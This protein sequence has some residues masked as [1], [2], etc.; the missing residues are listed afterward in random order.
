MERTQTKSDDKCDHIS[1]R[2]AVARR[3]RFICFF[4]ASVLGFQA[5]ALGEEAASRFDTQRGGRKRM[6][7]D[8]NRE[9]ANLA[10]FPVSISISG[11]SKVNTSKAGE[12]V[13]EGLELWLRADAISGVPE[14]VP[15]KVWPGS[16]PKKQTAQTVRGHTGPVFGKKM[17]NGKV[18]GLRFNGRNTLL[19]LPKLCIPHNTTAF[20]VCQDRKQANG[21][22]T[23]HGLLVASGK[24]DPY[25]QKTGSGY[26]ISYLQAGMDGF[27]VNLRNGLNNEY[28]QSNQP[29]GGGMEL[30]TFRKSGHHAELYRDGLAVTRANLQRDQQ[31]AYP[32]GYTLGG[33]K[34]K[35][36]YHGVIAEILVYD[37]ALTDAEQRKTEAYLS[38][39]Y[40]IP[41]LDPLAD[42]PRFID[43][44]TVIM[45][46]G[47]VDQPYL[48]TLKDGSWL[49][50]STTSLTSERGKD[51]T[52]VLSRSTDHGKT[53]T[54]PKSVI[55]ADEA[56]Q[57]S[58][59]TLCTTPFGRVYV[60]YNLSTT[61][62]SGAL[63]S[64]CY[65]FSDDNGKTWSRRFHLP[66]RKTGLDRSGEPF[67]SWSV[68][69]PFA[70]DGA[71]YVSFSKFL[72]SKK[73]TGEG[74]LIRSDNLMT[75]K[76][77]DQLRWEMLPGGE[78]GI[79]NNAL[80]GLQE[81]HTTVPLP[82]GG[83]Y[84]TFRTLE[85]YLGHAYSRDRG[86]TWPVTEFAT[87]TPG[88]RRI[89]QPRACGRVFHCRN[90][91][92]L[93][94]F[95][96]NDGRS[97]PARNRNRNPAW[98]TGG[99]LKG[100]FIHWSQPEILLF[101]F[102]FP[103]NHGMSY[104]DLI[105][106]DGRYWITESQKQIARIHEIEP[107]L[108]EGLWKQSESAVV[109][110]K[111]LL[112]KLAGD[113]MPPRT[114]PL[115][116]LPSAGGQGFSIDMLVTFE[117]LKPGQVLLD[118]RH[119]TR[120][121]FAVDTTASGTVRLT[122]DDGLHTPH[123][124]DCDTGLLKPGKKH[125][126]TFIVDGGPRIISVLIDGQ[127]CDGSEARQFGWSFYNLSLRDM[128][129]NRHL[130]IVPKFNGKLHALRIYNRPLR[131]SEAVGIW[132]AEN[133]K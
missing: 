13:A 34:G 122:L 70:L 30:V 104:P 111:G 23:F 109:P 68:S 118:G 83:I 43:N 84:S 31:A 82:D 1:G 127:L 108:L 15:V 22:S 113:P 73:R 61:S 88:G 45:K 59:G 85:G 76:D 132:N 101:G 80:G 89:K 42:D 77:P 86:K 57:P 36:F 90:G 107:S 12:P 4:I 50:V 81:E 56:P 63:C 99:V 97:T 110:E 116:S 115:K 52:L 32:R 19:E 3:Q 11:D 133:K 7:I 44:G 6:A 72:R 130:R 94:W 66:M 67:N 75:E 24:Q 112:L 47:Y 129:G 17:V 54:A 117:T 120:G 93:L 49:C 2:A 55:E 95:H 103:H 114:E 37:R 60:F 64:Y 65:K 106:A 28:I 10:R 98:I 121:G 74:W 16:G 27:A 20:I 21:K 79:R 33:M 39:K 51:R 29:N 128:I 35:R 71:V 48:T 119:K 123:T 5:L 38:A 53:W 126:I 25:D 8:S 102:G 62:P 96:N 46:T 14:G 124:W 41:L 131:T 91:K 26:G 100:G 69:Q 87:Y 105:E 9:D 40:W 125:Q 78:K 18:P 58:W 92:Y